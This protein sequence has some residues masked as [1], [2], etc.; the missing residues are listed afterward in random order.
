[1]NR[2]NFLL[3]STLYLLG[4]F[5]GLNPFSRVLAA[6]KRPYPVHIPPKVALIIDDVGHSPAQARQF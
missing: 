3:Q 5:W 4:G 6:V 2:R 1:M